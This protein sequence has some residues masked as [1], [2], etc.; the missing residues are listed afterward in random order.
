VAVA[1]VKVETFRQ[2]AVDIDVAVV[3]AVM[4]LRSDGTEALAEARVNRLQR[5][6]LG[7]FPTDNTL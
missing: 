4:R 5:A 1:Y 7:S 2:L 6:S 3:D